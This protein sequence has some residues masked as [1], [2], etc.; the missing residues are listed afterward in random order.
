MC[1]C[2]SIDRIVLLIV[3]SVL[4]LLIVRS[5]LALRYRLTNLRVWLKH[6]SQPIYSRLSLGAY[7]DIFGCADFIYRKANA[8]DVADEI[9]SSDTDDEISDEVF[10]GGVQDEKEVSLANAHNVSDTSGHEHK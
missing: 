6:G 9:L 5:V 7:N 10:E 3:R 1:E 2:I 4:V 8:D